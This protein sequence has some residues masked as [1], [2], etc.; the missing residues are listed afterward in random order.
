MGTPDKA[1]VFLARWL[2]LSEVERRA[3]SAIIHEIEASSYDIEQSTIDL[4]QRF[5][6]LA[7]HAG[8]Q[9]SRVEAI[10]AAARTIEAGGKEISLS[11]ATAYIE[12]VLVK[13]IDTVL[14]VSKNAMRM[15]YSLDDITAEVAA[16]ASCTAQLQEINQQTRF[17]AINAAIEAARAGANSGAFDVI[18]GEVRALSNQ[19]ATT[20]DVVCKRIAAIGDNVRQGHE[21]LQAIATVDMSE[22]IIAKSTLDQLLQGIILQNNNFSAVLNETADTQKELSDTIA[23]LIMGLQFQDRV[24]Q[25]LAHVVEALRVLDEVGD[26]LRA[27]TRGETGAAIAD[28]I[29]HDLLNRM[30]EKQTLGAVRKRFLA[31]LLDV[32][33][34]GSGALAAAEANLDAGDIELF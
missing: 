27:E 33:P 31:Q 13:V 23:P 9:V 24:S 4:N 18:A 3:F 14:M 25:H 29:D 7:E 28:G 5:R 19:T 22:H 34:L 6:V 2:E 15:V 11:E 32:E 21:V 20:V 12:S 8:A 10:A 30:V 17:L 26:S 1:G 16:A